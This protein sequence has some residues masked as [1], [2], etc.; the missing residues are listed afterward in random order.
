VKLSENILSKVE[1]KK[2]RLSK[3]IIYYVFDPLFEPAISD[4]L[5]APIEHNATERTVFTR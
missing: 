5:Q 3:P 1:K 4:V 2:R